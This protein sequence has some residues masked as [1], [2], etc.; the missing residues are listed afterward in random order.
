MIKKSRGMRLFGAKFNTLPRLRGNMQNFVTLFVLFSEFTTPRVWKTLGNF[1][2]T[3]IHA[4]REKRKEK[5]MYSINIPYDVMVGQK[6]YTLLDDQIWD[7][8]DL[9]AEELVSEVGSR[10]FWISSYNP[11]QD[12]MGIFLAGMKLEKRCS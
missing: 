2:T 12:D 3:T 8:D 1:I 11:P 7:D 6:V 5:E 10:G 9:I 4:V